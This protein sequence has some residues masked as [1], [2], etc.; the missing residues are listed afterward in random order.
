MTRFGNRK[1]VTVIM[2][3]SDDSKV[4]HIRN[5]FDQ[6]TEDQMYGYN[7]TCSALDARHPTIKVIVSWMP[8]EQLYRK[9]QNTIE[10]LYPGLCIY[11]PPM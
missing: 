7:S 6:E 3:G 10:S 2:D 1:F 4:R 9:V 8:T 11:N 5:L